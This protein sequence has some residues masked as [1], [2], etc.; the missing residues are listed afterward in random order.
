MRPFRLL[1]IC[2][3]IL[4]CA[5]PYSCGFVSAALAAPAAKN[6]P[7]QWVVKYQ[8]AKLVTGSPVLIHIVAP[9]SLKTLTGKWLDHDIAFFSVSAP[10]TWNAIAGMSLETKPGKYFL[11]LRGTT[12]DATPVQFRYPL[13]VTKGKY[14]S[15]SVKV[16]RDFTQPNPD[17]IERIGQEQTLKHEV[18][19][20]MDSTREWSGD[21]RPPVKAQISDTF[22]TRRVFNGKVQSVHQGLDYAVPEGTP[23]AALNRGIVLL[24]KPLFFEGNC[25]VLDHGQGLLTIYMHLSKLMVKEGATVERGDEL[26]LSG[27]T[28]RATGPHLHVAV[29]WQGVYLDPATLL[30][31]K[32]P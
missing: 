20:R 5:L 10:D 21:F 15:I 11:E 6:H 26:G 13:T 9:Q 3:G 14:R 19:S 18:F 17:Q 22:G 25:V 32:L 12:L 1:H 4:I 31:L 2:L 24:A 23:V 16:A 8:P 27:G 28:G 30:T 29:R 7:A